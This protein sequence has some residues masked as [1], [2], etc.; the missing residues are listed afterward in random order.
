MAGYIQWLAPRLDQVRAEMSA[1][2]DRY[3]EQAAHAGRHRRTPGIVA[4]L[5]IGWQQFFT[6]AHQSGALTRGEAEGHRAR[7]WSALIEVAH[8]QSEHQREITDADKRKQTVEEARGKIA[9]LRAELSRKTTD[10]KHK[11]KELKKLASES[12]HRAAVIISGASQSAAEPAQ[13][14]A[15]SRPSEPGP[16]DHPSDRPTPT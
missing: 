10:L 5:L 14:S 3:R 7:V 11:S 4:D 15:E 2:H 6:F 16:E 1:A 9:E 8:R 12:A 13:S